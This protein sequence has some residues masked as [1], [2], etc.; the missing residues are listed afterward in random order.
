MRG[1]EWPLY[2]VKKSFAREATTVAFGSTPAIRE[3]VGVK[4][5]S[6]RIHPKIMLHRSI[7]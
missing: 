3:F 4:P 1:I 2:A 6:S 5:Y 7:E